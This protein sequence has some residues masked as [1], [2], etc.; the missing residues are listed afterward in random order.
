MISLKEFVPPVVVDLLVRFN[1]NRHGF[2][3]DFDSWEVASVACEGYE[4]KTLVSSYVEKYLSEFK[5]AS[6][7]CDGGCD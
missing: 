6:L 3:G 7:I 5:V 2:L 4:S 1:R